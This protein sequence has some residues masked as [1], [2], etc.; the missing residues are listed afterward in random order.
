MTIGEKI[1]YCRKRTGMSQE[2]LAAELGISRQAV[3]NWE[4]GEATPDTGR[5]VTLARLFRVSTDYLLLDE[6]TE[7]NGLPSGEGSGS[8][9]EV[10]PDEPARAVRERR[11]RFR[12][13]FG[14]FFLAAG[15]LG[16]VCTLFGAGYAADR[17]T[18][19][20][21]ELGRFGTA[22]TET[23]LWMPLFVSIFVIAIG[24]VILFYEYR[25]ED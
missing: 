2:A 1:L 19:W 21:T 3:S 9:E 12:I 13:G 16:V 23:W 10:S 22:L 25:R 8:P 15:L 24:A 6:L 17:L 14:I 11:R 7:P 4:T 5:V 18:Y 20:Q